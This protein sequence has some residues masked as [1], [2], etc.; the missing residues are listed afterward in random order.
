MPDAIYKQTLDEVVTVIK[1]LDLP[2]IEDAEVVLRKLPWDGDMLHKGITVSWD[3]DQVDGV[4]SMEGTNERD[5]VGYPCHITLVSGT[6]RGWGDEMITISDW[7]QDIRR[8]FH[9]KRLSMTDASALKVV[10]QVSLGGPSIPKEYKKNLNVSQLT[11]WAW[12]LE[13]RTV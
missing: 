10:C 7:R 1:A 2:G 11:V 12:F 4:G 8:T 6:G 3:E 13:T 9:C 5:L